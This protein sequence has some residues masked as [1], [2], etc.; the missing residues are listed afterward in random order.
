[1]KL[2][3][4]PAV[5]ESLLSTV[6]ETGELTPEVEKLLDE[7]T[8]ELKVKIDA[9]LC[10]YRGYEAEADVLK[11]EAD[12]LLHH[13]RVAAANAERLKLY[14]KVTLER[15]RVPKLRTVKF[16]VR[17]QENNPSVVIEETVDVEALPDK[18]KV[19]TTAPSK[20]AMMQAHKNGEALPAGCT[21]KKVG[22]HIVV[23]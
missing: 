11:A 8:D 2:Y 1:M 15:M 17:I 6:Q 4:I 19:V 14:A 5:Y 18:F 22:T 21:V 13:A 3:E 7:I 20:K 10:V 23:Q 12:R 16:R 9:V